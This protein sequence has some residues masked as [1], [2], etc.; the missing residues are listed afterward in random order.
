MEIKVLVREIEVTD[1]G[2]K[3][4]Q[5]WDFMAIT[6]VLDLTILVRRITRVLPL[7]GME[8]LLGLSRGATVWIAVTEE[9]G[10]KVRPV[11][12]HQERIIHKAWWIIS[13]HL[14]TIFKI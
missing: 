5:E 2:T 6:R 10:T 7:I 8:V 3:A 1:P 12:M 13:R 9:A 11:L 14:E 4:L